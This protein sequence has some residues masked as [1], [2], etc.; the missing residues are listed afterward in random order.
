MALYYPILRLQEDVS[1]VQ[2]VY[3][4]RADNSPP[5]QGRLHW[6]CAVLGSTQSAGSE[7]RKGCVDGD[8]RRVGDESS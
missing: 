7:L 6:P 1:G 2:D 5:E 8:L 4:A 3:L